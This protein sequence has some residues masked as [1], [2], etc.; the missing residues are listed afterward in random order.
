MPDWVTITL[1]VVTALGG[2]TGVVKALRVAFDRID[3]LSRRLRKAFDMLEAME[4]DQ[5]LTLTFIRSRA[6][7]EAARL[8]MT[9]VGQRVFMSKADRERFRPI[10]QS[11]WEL[12]SQPVN[13]S[14][15]DS[16]WKRI[17]DRHSAWLVQNVCVPLGASS[18]ACL[19]MA[20]EVAREKQRSA[21][22]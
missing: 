3:K 17:E 8:G 6:R 21:T 11:L 4:G 13:A 2:F 12:A 7:S 18:G 5:R 1:A 22:A 14:D 10:E 20:M 15:S 9:V 16:L 19:E